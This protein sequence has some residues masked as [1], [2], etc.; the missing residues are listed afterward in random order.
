MSEKIVHGEY[1]GWYYRVFLNGEEIY[2]AGNSPQD[3]QVSV[4]KS[5]GVGESKMRQYCKQTCED[6]AFENGASNRGVQK[7]DI[8]EEERAILTVPLRDK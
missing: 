8:T 5:R 6:I 7:V 2:W 1:N 4:P 3:S